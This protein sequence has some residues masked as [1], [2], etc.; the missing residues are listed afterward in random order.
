MLNIATQASKKGKILTFNWRGG[1]LTKEVLKEIVDTLKKA[2]EERKKE[3][4]I[5]LN[6]SQAVIRVIYTDAVIVKEAVNIE[7]VNEGE[8]DCE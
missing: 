5:S 6:W 3:P 8:N 2:G 1:Y 7:E 4:Y